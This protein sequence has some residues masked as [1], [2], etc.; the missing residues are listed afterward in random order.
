MHAYDKDILAWSQE[1]ARLIRA[2]RFDLVDLEHVA[3]EIEDVGKSEQRELA[4][5]MT[6]LLAHL[7][8]WSF[9]PERR[10]ASWEKTI[11]AQRKELAYHLEETPSLRPKLLEPRWLDMVWSKAVAQ[12]VSETGL[13]SFPETCPWLIDEEVLN[14]YWFPAD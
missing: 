4:N 11:K 9:Q 6:V 1:Q 12:A 5:R 14:P 13:D 8:K 10:G 2:G 3:E 7:L